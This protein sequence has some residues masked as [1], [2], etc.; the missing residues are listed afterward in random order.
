M[1]VDID[2]MCFTEPYRLP[3]PKTPDSDVTFDHTRRVT[4]SADVQVT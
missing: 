1:C 3:Q 4:Q 2:D